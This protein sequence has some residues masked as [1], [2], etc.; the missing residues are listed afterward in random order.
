MKVFGIGLNKTGTKTL[1]RHLTQLGFRNRSYDSN[2]VYESESFEL[3]QQ[4]NLDALLDLL[5]DYD[6]CEDWPWCLVYRELDERFPDAK[7][8]LTIRSTPDVWYRSLCNMSV[9]IGPLPLFERHVYGSSMP[10]G[11][12]KEHI[13]I[14]QD[15]ERAVEQYFKD[16]PDKLLKLCWETAAGPQVLLDFLGLPNEHLEP[17]HVNKSPSRIYS[18]DNLLRAHLARIGYQL[19]YGPRAPVR[20]FAGKVKRLLTAGN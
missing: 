20:G 7:F 3:W 8:V 6:S 12:K 19:V 2:N 16:R 10:Q 15:H 1:G 17:V 14:Y 4:G 5:E 18:G 9:R 13:R 11:R